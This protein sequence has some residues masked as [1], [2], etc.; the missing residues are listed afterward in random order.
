MSI[1]IV[2]LTNG[3]SV[4]DF[5]RYFDKLGDFGYKDNKDTSKSTFIIIDGDVITNLN[6]SE[7]IND[8]NKYAENKT[9]KMLTVCCHKHSLHNFNLDLNSDLVIGYDSIS[10]QLVYYNDEIQKPTIEFDNITFDTH[11]NLK[12]SND[13]IDTHVYICSP[14]VLVRFTDNF[15]Y[16]VL[17]NNILQDFQNDF[18]AKEVSNHDFEKDFYINLFITKN[19][20]VGNITV[21]KIYIIFSLH[22]VLV[23]HLKQLFV[24]GYIHLQLIEII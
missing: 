8:H 14:K 19:I 17:Y 1:E 21:L 16:H 24:D 20:Y 4:G 7:V 9:E 22:I 6:L 3:S 18:I 15:D 2:K 5:L 10:N 11:P 12:I 13:C 23:K